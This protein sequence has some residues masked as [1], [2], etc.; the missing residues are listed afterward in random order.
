MIDAGSAR[1]W[2]LM[3]AGVLAGPIAVAD[4]D[5]A[6]ADGPQLWWT[7]QHDT[8]LRSMEASVDI[9]VAAEERGGIVMCAG[10]VWISSSAGLVRV[11]AWSGEMG[12]LMPA[13]G[14]LSDLLCGGGMLIGGSAQH[15][16]FAL[17]PSSDTDLRQ[18][19]REIGPAP[20][21]I[22]ATRTTVWVLPA[23][24]SEAHVISFRPSC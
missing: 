24:R 2:R 12:R 22:V 21:V 6:A 16:L 19:Q 11:N 3:E 17:D 7:S 18:I 15:G 8:M 20:Y 1:A 13:P 5:R 9:G 23:A 10:S 14:L 4:V